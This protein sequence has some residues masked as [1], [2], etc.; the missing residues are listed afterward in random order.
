[1]KSTL[2][3][4]VVSFLIIGFVLFFSVDVLAQCPMCKMAAES[5]LEGGGTEGKGLNR[6]ILYM[7]SFPYILVATLG[8]IWWRNKRQYTEEIYTEPFSDN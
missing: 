1:M 8:F 5:N 6:G 4:I 2:K 3:Y 7:L